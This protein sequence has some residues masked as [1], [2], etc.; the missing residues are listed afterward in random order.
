MP[1]G[2]DE[3]GI[4]CTLDLSGTY[5]KELVC[6]LSLEPNT[7]INIT[8]AQKRK[9]LWRCTNFQKLKELVERNGIENYFTFCIKW[10]EGEIP[11]LPKISSYKVTKVTLNKKDDDSRD[12][13][14]S[15]FIKDDIRDQYFLSYK[16]KMIIFENACIYNKGYKSISDKFYKSEN[17]TNFRTVKYNIEMYRE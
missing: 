11:P 5:V 16:D 9:D 13:F 6:D 12:Q 10:L 8:K 17:S 3:A 4:F 2:K 1:W 7:D 15:A 14:L